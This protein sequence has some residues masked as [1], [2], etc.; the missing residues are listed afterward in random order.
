EIGVE[1][2]DVL[3]KRIAVIRETVVDFVTHLELRQAQHRCLP[4]PQHLSIERG[5]ELRTFVRRQLNA[6]APHE[7]ARDLAL[8]VENALALDLGR[9]RGQ[10]GNDELIAEPMQ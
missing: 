1:L 10:Y 7:Q 5:V 2:R 8:D 9:M 4:Q 3:E 6:V